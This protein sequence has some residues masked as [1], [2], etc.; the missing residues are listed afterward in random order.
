MA[1]QPCSCMNSSLTLFIL[2]INLILNIYI[3]ILSINYDE[4]F[5]VSWFIVFLFIASFGG[6]FIDEKWKSDLKI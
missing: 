2:S 4:R 1:V 5:C 3:Y 6:G